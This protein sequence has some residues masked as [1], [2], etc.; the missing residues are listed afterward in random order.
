MRAI[1]GT[2]Q[3]LSIQ[4]HKKLYLDNQNK[5]RV[6]TW[7]KSFLV[8]RKKDLHLIITQKLTFMKSAGF[9]GWNPADFRWNPADFTGEIRHEIHRISRWN[10]PDFTGEIDFERPIARNGKPYVFYF[11]RGSETEILFTCVLRL[12]R[13]VCVGWTCNALSVFPRG[14]I[15]TPWKLQNSFWRW[16]RC[17]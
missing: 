9:H 2:Q 1:S 5:W 10:P 17:C 4:K 13:N 7:K 12:K 8:F 16:N 15:A 3:W 6:R 14:G 11:V